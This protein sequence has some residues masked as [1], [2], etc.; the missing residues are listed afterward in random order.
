MAS[1]TVSI[2]LYAELSSYGDSIDNTG[3][4]S[5][6]NVYLSP[7]STL[8][9]LMDYLRLCTDERGFTFINEEMSAMPNVQADLDTLL[10]DGDRILFFPLKMLPT[11]LHFDIKLTD[12]MTR[13]MRVG[14]DSGLCYLY[15]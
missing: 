13:M 1:I 10:L 9:D 11:P 12:E 6:L 8:K 2:R 7:G 15:E 3:S 4:Y 14:E 5:S